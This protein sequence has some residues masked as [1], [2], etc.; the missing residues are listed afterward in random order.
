MLEESIRYWRKGGIDVK[1]S[2]LVKEAAT[3]PRGRSLVNARDPKFTKSGPMPEWIQEDCKANNVFVPQSPAE[4][5]LVIFES[6]A[7]AYREVI[8]ELQDASG[9]KV[10]QI[11]VVGGGS[12]NNL[13]N[14]LTADA[15]GL[16]VLSGPT[17]ATAYGNLIVQLIALGEIENLNEGRKLISNSISQTRFLPN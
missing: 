13:L 8:A 16:M 3:L 5:A 10:A 2:D 4:V 12:A 9:I 1:V 17:E 14:Q 6:L 7:A 11:N 15:T